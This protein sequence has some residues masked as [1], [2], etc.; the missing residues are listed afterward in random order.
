MKDR[1]FKRCHGIDKLCL[2]M[3]DLEE[4]FKRKRLMIK[5][6]ILGGTKPS[7]AQNRYLNFHPDD[8][9]LYSIHH[10][11]GNMINVIKFVD[12]TQRAE[13]VLTP[14]PYPCHQGLCLVRCPKCPSSAVCA[15]SFVCDCEAYARQSSCKHLHLVAMKLE[16]PSPSSEHDYCRS[17][18][19]NPIIMAATNIT[20]KCDNIA[21]L[22]SNETDESQI[23]SANVCQENSP[24]NEN[25]SEELETVKLHFFLPS[26]QVSFLCVHR[27][28]CNSNKNKN[29]VLILK[30]KIERFEICFLVQ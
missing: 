19:S 14:N 26:I 23:G 21:T 5:H 25:E 10:A 7:R 6:G 27:I 28:G 30:Y 4:F 2:D 8:S 16:C 24:L 13:H 11:V 1:S 29:L 22:D 18:R 20:E 15:H 9:E 17:R 12:G 3:L